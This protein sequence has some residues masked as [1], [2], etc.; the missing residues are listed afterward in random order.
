M[1]PPT[2]LTPEQGLAPER[3]VAVRLRLPLRSAAAGRGLS[4][5]ALP[6]VGTWERLFAAPVRAA[7]S[8]ALGAITRV[9]S[10]P[11]GGL[12]FA[13]GEAAHGLLAVVDGD[14]ALG[15]H[16][17]GGSF[18]TERHLHAPAWLDLSAAWLQEPH[19]LDARALNAARVLELPRDAL[20]EVVDRHPS[21]WRPLVTLLARE[22]RGLAQNTHELMHKDAPARLAAWLLQ[23]CEPAGEE[24]TTAV[25]QLPVRKRDIASQLAITPETLSR[26]MR[27]F[28]SRDVISVA[29]Y[30]VQVLDLPAL[31][32]I[33]LGD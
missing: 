25:V 4:K 13:A 1:T 31:R 23:Q 19:A 27:S 8:A 21:L 30:T 26:L 28:S 3:A 6:D 16:G 12:V 33:A 14:V 17:A 22:V 18:R 9:L 5:D 11:P 29:G 15:S 32:R 10:F 24:A 7:E 20:C 2:I